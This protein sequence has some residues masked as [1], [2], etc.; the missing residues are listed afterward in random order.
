MKYRSF[1]Q[2]GLNFQNFWILVAD[3][4]ADRVLHE[5]TGLTTEQMSDLL[6]LYCENKIRRIMQDHSCPDCDGTKE[7]LH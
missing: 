7:L 6:S 1:W 5:D 4:I 2:T 3:S